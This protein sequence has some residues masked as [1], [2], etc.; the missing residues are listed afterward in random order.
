MLCVCVSP[1]PQN[2]IWMPEAIFMKPGMYIMASEPIS[3]AYFINPS[4]QSV[5]VYVYP[6]SLLGNGSVKTL[7]RQWTHAT[8]EE[9][10]DASF[11]MR[12]VSYRGKVGDYFFSEPIV[13]IYLVN[14]RYISRQSYRGS[15]L[16]KFPEVMLIVLWYGWK[17]GD[18]F[19]IAFRFTAWS[20]RDSLVSKVIYRKFSWKDWRR[21]RKSLRIVGVPA[22][23]RTGYLQY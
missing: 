21:S 10:L 3:T 16:F 19:R 17:R 22:E 23:I 20:I 8:I 2:Q 6:L 12:S 14:I 5:Y 18:C 13:L 1:P 9:L 11:T 4:H 15:D 7:S